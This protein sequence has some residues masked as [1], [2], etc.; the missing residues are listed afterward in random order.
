MVVRLCYSIC[1]P[2]HVC[3]T[4]SLYEKGVSQIGRE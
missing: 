2:V 3:T 1:A 4:E